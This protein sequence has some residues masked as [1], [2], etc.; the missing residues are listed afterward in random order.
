MSTTMENVRNGSTLGK[1]KQCLHCIFFQ[2]WGKIYLVY[3]FRTIEF[4]MC[5]LW[6]VVVP[7]LPM[8]S[9]TDTTIPNSQQ[10]V[11]MGWTP[12]VLTVKVLQGFFCDLMLKKVVSSAKTILKILN[13]Q[14]NCKDDLYLCSQH[15]TCWWPST[16][17]SWDIYILAQL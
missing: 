7:W 16:V 10:S 17:G 13:S 15:C 5:S 2:F 11:Y 9:S 12:Q 3:K 8:N 14:I 1:A 6:S 4:S